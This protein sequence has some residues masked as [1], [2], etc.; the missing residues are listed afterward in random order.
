MEWNCSWPA[1][2]H[3]I[4]FTSSSNFLTYLQNYFRVSIPRCRWLL[5]YQSSVNLWYIVIANAW[6]TLRTIRNET[7]LLVY[8]RWYPARTTNYL[9][10]EG[11]SFDELKKVQG[12]RVEDLWPTLLNC[13]CE[14]NKTIVILGFR[15]CSPLGLSMAGAFDKRSNDDAE[16]T[17]HSARCVSRFV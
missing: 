11:W 16:I 12:L 5:F 17:G 10:G 9:S 7:I 14:P 2:S 15:F 4:S 3:N 13:T 1:V 8:W 6:Q